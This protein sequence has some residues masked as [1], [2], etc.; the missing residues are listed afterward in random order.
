MYPG[1]VVFCLSPRNLCNCLCS[2]LGTVKDGLIPSRI[3]FKAFQASACGQEILQLGSI[4]GACLQTPYVLLMLEPLIAFGCLSK[5]IGNQGS[6]ARAYLHIK[7][8]WNG[9]G[10]VSQAGRH[11]QLE[12]NKWDFRYDFG[13]VLSMDTGV[14]SG[15]SKKILSG[16]TGILKKALWRSV[17][18]K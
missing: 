12:K 8:G 9:Q 18:K 13:Q 15:E 11:V 2:W 4:V 16:W 5:I 1:F 17:T 10:S 14:L 3:Y 6:R 7:A